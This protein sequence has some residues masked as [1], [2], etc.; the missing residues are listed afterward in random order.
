MRVSVIFSCTLPAA[1]LCCIIGF[2]LL[3]SGIM[4]GLFVFLAGIAWLLACGLTLIHIF[5]EMD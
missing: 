4:P 5:S 3:M 2:S 1:L